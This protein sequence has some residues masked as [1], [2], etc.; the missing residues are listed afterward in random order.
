[1]L[2][3]VIKDMNAAISVTKMEIKMGSE[4]LDKQDAEAAQ[5]EAEIAE[6]EKH[7]K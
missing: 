5:L 2:I 4:I 7:Y 1:M 6:A 3:P